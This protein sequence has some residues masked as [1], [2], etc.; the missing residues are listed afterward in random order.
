MSMNLIAEKQFQISLPEHWRKES[1]VVIA[2]VID[3]DQQ[4]MFHVK[5]VQVPENTAIEQFSEQQVKALS[6]QNTK[7]K[8]LQ[9]G[10]FTFYNGEGY[11]IHSLWEKEEG[12][13]YHQW[14]V[15]TVNKQ[16]AFILTASLP[17]ERYEKTKPEIEKMFRSFQLLQPR[18]LDDGIALNNEKK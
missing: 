10:P 11:E 4:V 5:S 12:S 7:V 1:T 2:G 18:D 6:E 13:P 17:E 8:V 15:I 16:L 3:N 14:Q 9:T